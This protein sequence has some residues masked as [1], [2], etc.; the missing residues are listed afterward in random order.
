MDPRI[1]WIKEN[2]KWKRRARSKSEYLPGIDKAYV[3]A[4]PKR[5]D[6]VMERLRPMVDSLNVLDAI[7]KDKL[8]LE[9]LKKREFIQDKQ[10]HGIEWENKPDDVVE[11]RTRGF[12]AA[13]MS[14][15]ACML[16]FLS[17]PDAKRA[18]IMEDDAVV[19]FDRIAKAVEDGLSF[20]PDVLYLCYCLHDGEE[21]IGKEMLKLTTPWCRGGYVVNRETAELL[22][23][24]S[25]PMDRTGDRTMSKL[26]NENGSFLVGPKKKAIEQQD[27]GKSMTR[28]KMEGDASSDKPSK[29]I[30]LIV[31]G[32]LLI[33]GSILL[34]IDQRR[35]RRARNDVNAR[36]FN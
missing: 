6:S 30:P 10:W 12:T 7:H 11:A 27:E 3:I 22:A 31:I 20:D 1:S 2:S 21:D 23:R 29:Y 32:A 24:S 35:K 18:L 5:Y 19:D 17:D 9:D 36:V 33:C 34:W 8:D 14:H 26:L 4:M 28:E 25:F 15:L 16:D 13:H